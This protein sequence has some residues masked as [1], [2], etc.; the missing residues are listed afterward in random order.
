MNLLGGTKSKITK[1][2]NGEK[3]RYLEIN[4]AV[5][6]HCNVLND[7]YQQNSRVFSFVL[8]KSFRQL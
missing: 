1:D 7:S 5:L 2:E 4:E 6:I 8:N 3:V